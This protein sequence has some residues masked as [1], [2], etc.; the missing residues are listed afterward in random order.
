MHKIDAA[1]VYSFEIRVA[2][3]DNWDHVVAPAS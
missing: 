2:A 1:V 3:G